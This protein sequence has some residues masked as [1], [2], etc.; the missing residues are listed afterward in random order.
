MSALSG[1]TPILTL[2]GTNADKVQQVIDL[3]PNPDAAH[4]SG[5]V[6]GGGQGSTNTYLDEMSPGAAAQLRVELIALKASLV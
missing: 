6:A 5:A 1:V 2:A 3:I 4:G